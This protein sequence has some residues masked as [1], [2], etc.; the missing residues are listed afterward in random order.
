M[1]SIFGEFYTGADG[2]D[3]FYLPFLKTVYHIPTD[4]LVTFNAFRHRFVIAFAL[5][6]IFY[7]FFPGDVLLCVFVG[8]LFYALATVAY[9]KS[10][11]PKYVVQ[12]GVQEGDLNRAK[13]NEQQ[14]SLAKT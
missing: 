7:S 1:Q 2:K 13:Q 8:A 14:G 4:D 10:I 11:L 3:Y 6:A 5:G 9:L 12:K